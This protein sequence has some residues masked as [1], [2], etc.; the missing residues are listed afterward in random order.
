MDRVIGAG[1]AEVEAEAG[2]VGEAEDRRAERDRR[3]IEEVKG[4]AAGDVDGGSGAD[5]EAG[6]EHAL[7]D[8]EGAAVQI[9]RAGDGHATETGLGEVGLGD[10]TDRAVDRQGGETVGDVEVRASGADDDVLGGRGRGRCGLGADA[11]VGEHA[12]VDEDGTGTQVGALREGEGARVDAQLSREGVGA[13][14]RDHAR[15]A[16]HHIGGAAEDGGDGASA[17]VEVLRRGED[18]GGA[19]DGA[20]AEADEVDGLIEGRDVESTAVHRH[21]G[22]VGQGAGGPEGQGAGVDEG[23]A[24]EAVGARERERARADL[25]DGGRGAADGA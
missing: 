23:A 10:G 25:G 16:L 12:A 21:G 9:D 18:A 14:E 7:G 2:A 1:G 20:G 3:T 11:R 15:G 8:R 13:R 4:R 6:A 19:V 22:E 17:E 5:R 24:G